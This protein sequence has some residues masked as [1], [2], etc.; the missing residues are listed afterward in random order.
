MTWLDS[1]LLIVSRERI[2]SLNQPNDGRTCWDVCQHNSKASVVYLNFC[3]RPQRQYLG[4]VLTCQRCWQIRR[5]R[6]RGSCCSFLSL[7]TV[8]QIGIVAE[9]IIDLFVCILIDV[10]WLV[11]QVCSTHFSCDSTSAAWLETSSSIHT[12]HPCPISTQR[13]ITDSPTFIITSDDLSNLS[14]ELDFNAG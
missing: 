11:H 4:K 12:H 3:L 2:S 8:K 1:K 9:L 6:C 13:I 10:R 7:F 14:L 5:T